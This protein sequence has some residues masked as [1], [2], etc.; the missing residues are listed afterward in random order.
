MFRTEKSFEIANYTIV[1]VAEIGECGIEASIERLIK[2]CW[3]GGGCKIG[4]R[5]SVRLF[6]ILNSIIE[7]VKVIS[8]YGTIES[9]DVAVYKGSILGYALGTI[10]KETLG[11]E[12]L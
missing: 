4:E 7:I 12:K 2:Q 10:V 8:N 5:L 11:I 1:L 6:T 9:E 3:D